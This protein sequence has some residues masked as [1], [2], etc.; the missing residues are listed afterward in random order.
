MRAPLPGWDRVG[1]SD[2]C[3]I[4]PVGPPGGS[5]TRQHEQQLRNLKTKKSKTE[6]PETT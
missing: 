2:G 3:Q 1:E 5:C 6:T 4:R